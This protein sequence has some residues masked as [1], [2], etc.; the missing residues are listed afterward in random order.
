[1]AFNGSSPVAKMV[2][3]QGGRFSAS[4]HTIGMIVVC[5][6]WL[7]TVHRDDRRTEL[8]LEVYIRGPREK[9]ITNNVYVALMRKGGGRVR[10][11]SRVSET[12]KSPER[13][14]GDGLG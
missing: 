14:C 11:L 1:M 4:V 9:T 8:L 3:A 6:L 2:L 10:R 13:P 7:P 5:P 12:A